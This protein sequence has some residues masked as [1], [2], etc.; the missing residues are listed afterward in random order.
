MTV[1]DKR[2]HFQKKDWMENK[3]YWSH[4]TVESR[5]TN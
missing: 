3:R 2:A 4:P 5:S 1:P